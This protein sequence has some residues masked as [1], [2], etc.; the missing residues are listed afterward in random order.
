M[1]NRLA[2]I[3][4]NGFAL[5]R[6]IPRNQKRELRKGSTALKRL[7]WQPRT[8]PPRFQGSTIRACGLNDRVRNG[9]G[10]T[11]TAFVTNTPFESCTALL[12]ALVSH[13]TS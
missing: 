12:F 7:G 13:T 1:T 11:P 6:E 2:L 5:N 4:I 10:W 9:T 3:V 8:L